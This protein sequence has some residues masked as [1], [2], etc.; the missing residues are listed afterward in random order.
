MFLYL[1]NVTFSSIKIGMYIINAKR[2]VYVLLHAA[3]IKKTAAIESS[4]M[5]SHLFVLFFIIIYIDL[6]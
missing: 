5:F 6:A 4:K 3:T 2:P 1:L